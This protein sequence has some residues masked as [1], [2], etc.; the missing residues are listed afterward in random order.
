MSHVQFQF[1][2]SDGAKSFGLCKTARVQSKSRAFFPKRSCA[3]LVL[4]WTDGRSLHWETSGSSPPLE[5]LWMQNRDKDMDW[6]HPALP[7]PV[8]GALEALVPVWLPRTWV[9]L[10]NSL[11]SGRPS[12]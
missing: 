7:H 3:S 5:G 4:G 2:G 11:Q 6:L 1:C 10:L 12:F 9:G 8:C